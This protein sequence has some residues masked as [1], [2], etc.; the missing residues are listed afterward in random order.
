[1]NT[2]TY[3]SN[4]SDLSKI[5]NL[6]IYLAEGRNG[7]NLCDRVRDLEYGLHLLRCQYLYFCTPKASKL[8]TFF[9]PSSADCG[10]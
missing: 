6:S 5:S 4:L 7:G 9:M 1:M 8:S 2:H 10:N 3:L